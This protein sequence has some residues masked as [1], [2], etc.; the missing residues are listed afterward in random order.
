MSDED[1]KKNSNNVSGTLDAMWPGADRSQEDEVG[2]KRPPRKNQFKKGQSGNPK[3]RPRKS[4]PRGLKLSDAPSDHIFEEEVYRPVTLR[5]NGVPIELPALQAVRR[6]QVMSAIKGNRFAQKE[7]IEHAE[8]IEQEKFQIKINRYVELKKCKARGENTLTENGRM[9]ALDTVLLPHP[10]DIVLD[11]ATAEA[12][13]DGPENQDD[14]RACEYSMEVRDH[15]FLCSAYTNI[16]RKRSK[17]KIKE[18]SICR[19]MLMAH[20]LDHTLPQRF[21]CD[22]LEVIHEMMKFSCLHKKEMKQK[23]ASEWKH[24][25]ATRPRSAKTRPEV[26][27]ALDKCLKVLLSGDNEDAGDYG[28]A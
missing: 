10:D 25:E 14:L 4:K 2:Y 18:G 19:F 20:L 12:Y 26:Q 22:D 7:V 24:L 28:T 15:L 9:G 27:R 16:K 13:V 1:K 21:R 5:E 8:K 11:R 23:I 17:E 6:S 3:G